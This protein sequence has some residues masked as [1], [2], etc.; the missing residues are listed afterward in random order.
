MKIAAYS[1]DVR[2]HTPTHVGPKRGGTMAD[3]VIEISAFRDKRDA[4]PAKPVAAHAPTTRTAVLIVA[5]N[6][7]VAHFLQ[8]RSR[9]LLPEHEYSLTID[10]GTPTAYLAYSCYDVIVLDSGFTGD[11]INSH[12]Q[13]ARNQK[14][15]LIVFGL[16]LPNAHEMHFGAFCKRLLRNIQEWMSPTP[17][18][19]A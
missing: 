4:Q 7:E 8:R 10:Y 15:D 11:E 16:W 12:L 19:A 2:T 13:A 9:E 5:S 6:L 18:P 3:N 17:T 14:R 1:L